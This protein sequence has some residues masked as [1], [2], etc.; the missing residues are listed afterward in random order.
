MRPM[1]KKKWRLIS[2]GSILATVFNLLTIY[3]FYNWVNNYASYNKVYGSIG[4]VIIL[5]F[6]IYLNAF[7]LLIGF[8]INVSMHKLNTTKN[9][10]K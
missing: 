2:W 7:V 9:I 4:T 3:I 8:E 6:L 5:L 10:E 1:L